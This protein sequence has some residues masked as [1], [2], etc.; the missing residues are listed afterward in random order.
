ME[1]CHP[2]RLVSCQDATSLPWEVIMSRQ[3]YGKLWPISSRIY[4]R[5]VFFSVLIVHSSSFAELFPCLPRTEI[6]HIWIEYVLWCFRLWSKN[7]VT[8]D[9]SMSL[10]FPVPRNVTSYVMCVLWLWFGTH[11]LA[12]S[13]IAD[14]LLCISFRVVSVFTVSLTCMRELLLPL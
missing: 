2:L 3:H 12:V 8:L 9:L 13:Q 10:Y 11:Q 7:S 14:D 4:V 1:K 5:S 6:M